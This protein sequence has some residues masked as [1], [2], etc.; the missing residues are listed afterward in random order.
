M[1]SVYPGLRGSNDLS[2]GRKMATFQLFFQS[3]RAKDLSVSLYCLD[4]ANYLPIKGNNMLTTTT[5]FSS[6]LG[7]DETLQLSEYPVALWSE[8]REDNLSSQHQGC[9]VI[10]AANKSLKRKHIQPYMTWDRQ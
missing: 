2:V 3:G 8:V 6:F 7:P 5:I 1:L 10:L 9:Y 4:I